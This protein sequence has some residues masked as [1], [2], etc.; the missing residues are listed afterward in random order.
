MARAFISYSTKDQELAKCF[1]DFLQL[2]MGIQRG[3][4]FCTAFSDA[5]PTGENFIEKIRT[6]I[7]ACSV[8]ISLITEAYLK[9]SF[10]IAEMGV[11]WGMKKCCFPLLLVPY[12]RL[13]TTPLCGM[14]M[15]RLDSPADISTIYD[16]L[17]VHHI[18]PGRQTAEF[19][20]RLPGFISYVDNFQ[21]GNYKIEKDK[22]GYYTTVITEIRKVSEKYRCY[23]IK[24][25]I[26][27]PPDHGNA[28]SDWIFFWKGMYPDLQIGD[29]I[30]FKVSKS[31]IRRFDDLGNARNLYPS[32]L[33]KI[34]AY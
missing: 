23:G 14:Q 22:S 18:N 13:N 10:C 6:E 30:R 11:A 16:E 32:A 31:E 15:R 19:N 1:I 4:I 24:G 28:D 33:E 29:W 26:Q 21:K 2:G 9:S 5:L 25:Q 12:E 34:S 17:F 3:D 7:E 8:V 20:K 27:D